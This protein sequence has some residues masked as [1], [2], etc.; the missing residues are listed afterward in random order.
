MKKII[1]LSL[2][3]IFLFSVTSAFAA[4]WWTGTPDFY[5]NETAD[6]DT[7]AV[8]V[9]TTTITDRYN[10]SSNT[11][12]MD[13]PYASKDANL[14]SYYRGADVTDETGTNDLTNVG[15]G[16]VAGKFGNAFDTDGAGSNFNDLTFTSFEN[17]GAITIVAWVNPDVTNVGAQADYIISLPDG[18]GANG[19]DLAQKNNHFQWVL[20]THSDSTVQEGSTA[21]TAGTWYMLSITYDGTNSRGYVNNVLEFTDPLTLGTGLKHTTG[22]IYIGRQSD[23]AGVFFNGQIDEVKVYNRGL[24]TAEITVLYNNGKRYIDTAWAGS[25]SNWTSDTQTMTAGNKLL[26]TTI[27]L[28]SSAT[29]YLTKVEWLSNGIIVASNETDITSTGLVTYSTANGL[30]TGSFDY[31][32]DSYT[33]TI[34]TYFTG[35]GTTTPKVDDIIGYYE[36][37]ETIVW[38]GGT[39]TDWNVGSNWNTSTV[40]GTVNRVILNATSERQPNLTSNS[41]AYNISI[42]YGASLNTSGYNLQVGDDISVSGLLNVSGGKLIMNGDSDGD[43]EL[44]IRDG[45]TMYLLN[46]GNVTNG[47]ADSANYQFYIADGS[48]MSA[49]DSYIRKAG[50]EDVNYHR[51]VDVYSDSVNMNNMTISGMDYIGLYFSDSNNGIYNNIT[52]TS[53]DNAVFLNSSSNSN[54]FINSTLISSSDYVIYIGNSNS[55]NFTTSSISGSSGIFINSGNYNFFKG[56][57]AGVTNNALYYKGS[58]SIFRNSNFTG[59][60]NQLNS[61]GGNNSFINSNFTGT[62]SDAL[63]VYSTSGNN[64]IYNAT[65][66]S[67]IGAGDYD[68]EFD[69][70]GNNL[71]LVNCSFNANKIAWTSSTSYLFV[72]YYIDVHMMN[73]SDSNNTLNA[74]VTMKDVFDSQL[75]NEN[76]SSTGYTSVYEI[77][78]YKQNG[79]LTGNITSYDLHNISAT[80]DHYNAN[81][82]TYNVTAQK[83]S[84]A[85]LYLTTATPGFTINNLYWLRTYQSDNY[86]RSFFTEKETVRI[87]TNLSGTIVE[88]QLYPRISVYYPN[89][90][91]VVN[92]FDM[93][94]YSTGTSGI[95]YYDY[96]INTSE[97]GYYN[98]SIG[99][100]SITNAFYSGYRWQDNWTNSSGIIYPFEINLTVNNSAGS[101]RHWEVIDKYINFSSG[102]HENSVRVCLYNGTDLIEIPSQ[103]YNKTESAGVISY[104]NVVFLS[105]LNETQSRSYNLYYK[106]SDTGAMNY[107]TDLNYT[108]HT[109]YYTFENK[110]YKIQTN[111]TF[112]GLMYSAYNKL[113]SNTNLSG[114][115]PMQSMPE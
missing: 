11:A 18:Y 97:I 57:A 82:T 12:E 47:A 62:V 59:S 85:E 5:I 86:S 70:S 16:F 115:N 45:G 95:Y 15:A 1:I 49:N 101:E 100:K 66:S 50:W 79:T 73:S 88:G 81:S 13:F 90:T 55:T 53:T 22:D 58:D 60:T 24:T 25:A 78:A 7:P 48:N 37:G 96:D 94:N 35:D 3:V 31:I 75:F 89:G 32:N 29:A 104:A 28:T 87:I 112:G 21:I 105:S 52:I 23:Y 113:G 44:N 41:Y 20:I 43:C 14:I 6:Y 17:A 46:S 108:N 30:D 19:I 68:I 111:K 4:V 91:M 72:K 98:V 51:G 106:K 36:E 34:R 56:M 26:N 9:N 69:T 76:T 40:P 102:A 63:Y 103:V 109:G 2:L 83:S 114:L 74:N 67:D 71:T 54:K 110:N 33:F 99:T 93:T 27:N 92:Q 39:S 64:S 61:D 65:F 42:P 80:A 107:S 10:Q 84:T 38:Q 8:K 77:L